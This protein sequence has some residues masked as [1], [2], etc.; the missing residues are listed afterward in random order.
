MDHGDVMAP[1]NEA[2]GVLVKDAGAADGIWAGAGFDEDD[3]QT[4]SFLL[5]PTEASAQR[6]ATI[7]SGASLLKA[8]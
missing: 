8:E 7:F 3:A 6:C 1:L 5:L 2:I 4:G